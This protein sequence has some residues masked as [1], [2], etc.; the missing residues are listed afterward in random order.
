M[1]FTRQGNKYTW[2][3][4]SLRG[5]GWTFCTGVP[6]RHILLTNRPLPGLDTAGGSASRAFSPAARSPAVRGRSSTTRGK[7]QAHRARRDPTDKGEIRPATRRGGGRG[8]A[9]PFPASGRRTRGSS[10]RMSTT[11]MW[12]SDSLTWIGRRSGEAGC[13]RWSRARRRQWR[14]GSGW[15]KSGEGEGRGWSGSRQGARGGGVE[16]LGRQN[17]GEV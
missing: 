10:A 16:T 1:N 12:G 17:L 8:G 5:G 15:S 6:K 7:R 9:T 14:G 2:N 11:E 4:R 13:R 3:N